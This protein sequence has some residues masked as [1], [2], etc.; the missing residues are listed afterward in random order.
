MTLGNTVRRGTALAQLDTLRL[1][2]SLA[3][4]QDQL[5]T[6]RIRLEKAL[7]FE[8]FENEVVEMQSATRARLDRMKLRQAMVECVFTKTLIR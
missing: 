7:P 4:L 2:S 5:E 6:M 3:E 1:A 8:Q